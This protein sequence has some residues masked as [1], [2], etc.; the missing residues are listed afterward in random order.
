M[1]DA[2]DAMLDKLKLGKS[3]EVVWELVPLETG[4]TAAMG[5]EVKFVDTDIP[6]A[7]HEEVL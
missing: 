7:L 5:L 6:D 3:L 2:G 4:D 1:L